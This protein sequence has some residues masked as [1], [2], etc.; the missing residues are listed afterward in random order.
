MNPKRLAELQQQR[1]LVRQHLAWLEREIAKE[2]SVAPP[3]TPPA[4]VSVAVR[5]SPLDTAPQPDPSAAAANA[6]RG[7]L[8]LFFAVIAL[9]ALGLAAVYF[10]RYRDR[11]LL[12]IPKDPV[13]APAPTK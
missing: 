10:L 11:P 8:V 2:H 9:M 6:R 5:P 12:F 13:T 1:E 7:C 3:A 4:V